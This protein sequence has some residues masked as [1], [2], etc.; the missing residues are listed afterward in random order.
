MAKFHIRAGYRMRFYFA[1]R[2]LGHSAKYPKFY[3]STL[4]TMQGN[5]PIMLL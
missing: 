4:G 2:L 1:Y 3:N 5:V